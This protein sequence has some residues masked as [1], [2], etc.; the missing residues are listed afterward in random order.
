VSPVSALLVAVMA[1]AG[2][3][4]LVAGRSPVPSSSWR[5]AERHWVRAYGG[6]LVLLAAAVTAATAF[7]AIAA[8]YALL[9][10]AFVPPLLAAFEDNRRPR[11]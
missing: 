5:R 11:R 1:M 9:A 2:L 7:H 3:F 10:A 4:L 6:C 8:T